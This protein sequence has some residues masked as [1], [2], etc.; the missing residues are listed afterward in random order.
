M[1]RPAGGGAAALAF[2]QP[3]TF[4]ASLSGPGYLVDRLGFGAIGAVF[5]GVVSA[6]LGV[7]GGIIKVPL[8]N[9]AMGVPLKVATATSNMMIGITATSS[10]VIYL[11]RDEIDP[12]IAGP[13]ALG[14][15]V[16]AS[17]GAR[18][19]NRIDTRLLRMLFVVVLLV[20]A[21]QMGLKAVG[22]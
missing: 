10:A 11:L 2:A 20:T 15:F 17:V 18:V 13:V 6:L 21:V 16:G 9:L 5:A 12:Y 8:M 7:G 14:V 19:V 4:A 3:M 22:L 1:F